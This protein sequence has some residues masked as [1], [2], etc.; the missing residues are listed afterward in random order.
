MNRKTLEYF[1]T[2]AETL[3]FTTTARKHFVVQTTVSRQIALLEQ[4][5]GFML[6]ERNTA[7]VKLTLAGELFL[8]D[9]KRILR[10][11]DKAIEKA[12]AVNKTEILR[13]GHS[14]DRGQI[15]LR[16]VLKIFQTEYSDVEI[17]LCQ[18]T[19]Y[20]L[21]QKLNNDVVDVIAIYRPQLAD[22][23]G[24]HTIEVFKSGMAIGVAQ[25][26]RFA[27]RK[28]VR[29]IELKDEKILIPNKDIL[30]KQHEYIVECCRKDGYEPNLV[31]A[32]S[33]DTQVLMVQLGKGIGFF[34]DYEITQSKK[35][36]IKFVKLTNT[37]H[38]YHI[39][40]AWKK[41]NESG[42]LKKFVRATRKFCH[43]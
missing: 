26:H 11:Y 14:S 1:I 20:E 18:A 40:F 15:C 22:V 7:G 38:I 12:A 41:N 21:I 4:E 5:I 25:N 31:E 42:S 19:P 29:S 3:N 23:P 36:D 8:V 30:K 17:S 16:D 28:T 13:V 2:L 10:E 35:S 24:I 37:N 27:G 32:D 34:S 6:F 9:I 39:D 43:K 33:F